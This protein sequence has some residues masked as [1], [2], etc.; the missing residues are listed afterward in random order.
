MVTTAA[1]RKGIAESGWIVSL[2]I[3][4]VIL[5]AS[6]VFGQKLLDHA[7]CRSLPAVDRASEFLTTD[8]KAISWVE[9]GDVTGE[10]TLT[11]KW[12]RPSGSLHREDGPIF[13]G[14]AGATY[15]VVPV[16]QEF[17]IFADQDVTSNPGEW[18]VELYLDGHRLGAQTFLIVAMTEIADYGD[19]PDDQPCGY[20]DNP[21]TDVIG[22][23]PTLFDTRNSRIPGSPGAHALRVGEE[24]LGDLL[25]T[26]RE[27]DAD[28][29]N[30]P[31][32]APN[33]IDDDIDDGLSLELLPSG[34]LQL[35]VSV[36]VASTAPLG[37]RYLNVLYDLNQDG[38]WRETPTGQ[39][40]IIRNLEISIR[41]A[42]ATYVE[43]PILVGTNWIER[44]SRPRWLRL[45]LTRATVP[46]TRYMAVGG[47][48]GSGQ[49]QAGEIEDYKIGVA[50]AEDI[51]W[52]VRST[53]RL[54]WAFARAQALALAWSLSVAQAQVTTFVDVHSQV[55]AYAQAAEAAS[56]EAHQEALAIA[57]EYEYAI[58]EAE[59][60]EEALLTLPCAVVSVRAG[61][62]VQATLEAVAEAAAY[63]RASAG[64]A[65]EASAQALAWAQ[66]I[67]TSLAHARSA[68][69]SYSAAVAQA[70][71]HAEALAESWASA[72]AWAT[73]LAQ[74][75]SVGQ[76]PTQ[77]TALALAWVQI[78]AGTYTAVEVDV[79]VSAQTLA[80]S[81]AEAI[82]AAYARAETAVL[83][84]A[85]AEANA[86]AWAEAVA[87]AFAIVRVSIKAMV[88][89]AAA[90]DAA[91][92]E[93]CCVRNYSKA[94]P[95]VTCPPCNSCCPDCPK[96]TCPKC[97][98]CTEDK[99]G[100]ETGGGAVIPPD[101]L[102]CARK[103]AWN[104][105]QDHRTGDAI[106]D[107]WERSGV[108]RDN[109][110]ELCCGGQPVCV[111]CM[112]YDVDKYLSCPESRPSEKICAIKLANYLAGAS[113]SQR[114]WLALTY[115][116]YY[117]KGR[118]NRDRP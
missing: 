96:V 37:K 84:A 101:V 6:G 82:A 81:Y 80:L 92:L 8:R 89:A 118:D 99:P 107:R 27:R 65:A 66:S 70:F 85:E 44:I 51:A 93:D 117:W 30:D 45:A 9:I 113:S 109:P 20:S 2:A 16:A 115:F 23:F 4:A 94:C 87:D 22:R 28:D 64:A 39:E 14:S 54:A 7:M 3:L 86:T 108:T 34:Q 21:A 53:Y 98:P 33:L 35:R 103:L 88:N 97:P 76:V 55:L 62:C 38:E 24:A 42:E 46:E 19:A 5:C 102:D 17:A 13:I 10:H 57:T 116:D 31:D 49:F 36:Q 41:P 79:G 40:W 110:N 114:Q 112:E 47:W 68:A 73:A 61:A 26:S 58:V 60:Y 75:T 29:P 105:G 32:Q 83:A 111:S 50:R 63:A 72:R 12:F 18:Q 43:I 106:G 52:A 74:A 69:I 78:V 71:A 104:R 77:T 100:G 1:S 25:L 48:D 67:A 90:V 56:A 91:V 11:W 95:P 15:P 59:A